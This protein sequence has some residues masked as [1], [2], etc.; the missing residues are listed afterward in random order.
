ML[1]NS[2]KDEGLKNLLAVNEREL[3]LV[4]ETTNSILNGQKIYPQ[5]E[6]ELRETKGELTTGYPLFRIF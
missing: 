6:I 5:L 4:S 1:N 3:G 2:R